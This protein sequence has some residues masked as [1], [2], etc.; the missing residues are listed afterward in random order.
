VAL[1]REALLGGY[2]SSR[3]LEIHGRR[4]LDGAFGPGGARVDIHAKDA[5]IVLD[6]A[7]RVGLALPGFEPVAAALETLIAEGDGGLDHSALITLLGR[8]EPV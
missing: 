1:V 6:Q 2:A 3:V 7:K 8:D 5:R 4:M